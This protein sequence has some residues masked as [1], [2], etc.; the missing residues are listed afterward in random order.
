MPEGAVRVDRKSAFG[1]PYKVVEAAG[2]LWLVEDDGGAWRF[3][4]KQEAV[5]AAVGLY[6]TWIALPSNRLLRNR[7]RLT[8]KDK[9]PACWCRLDGG[10]CHA[11]VILE[12][13]RS[14]ME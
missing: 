6:R 2:G 13:A 1:N 11:D 14:P 3:P 4:T 8:F 12:I 5:L 10:P 9:S 7:M